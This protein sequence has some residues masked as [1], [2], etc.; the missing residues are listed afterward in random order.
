MRNELRIRHHQSSELSIEYKTSTKVLQPTMSWASW[1]TSN[2]VFLLSI[3]LSVLCVSM[4]LVACPSFFPLRCPSR[5]YKDVL[6]FLFVVCG[7]V[8]SILRIRC[9]VIKSGQAI[10]YLRHAYLICIKQYALTTSTWGLHPR[11]TVASELF[12]TNLRIQ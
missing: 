2:H 10:V 8:I 7:L 9:S 6:F 3:V 5:Q 4:S 1:V 11:P 12:I